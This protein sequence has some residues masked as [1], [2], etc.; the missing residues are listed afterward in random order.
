MASPFRNGRAGIGLDIELD[1]ELD[2]GRDMGAAPQAMEWS[3]I[4]LPSV[5]TRI[6]MKPKGP[7]DILVCF[8]LP[9]AA[10]AR[11]SSLM[12]SALLK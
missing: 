7:I 4:A 9:P 11:P 3:P 1:I 8:T 12:Q 10:T 6:E 5:S 2:I